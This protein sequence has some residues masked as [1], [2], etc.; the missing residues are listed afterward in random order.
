MAVITPLYEKAELC[1]AS[2]VENEERLLQEFWSK[3]NGI[4]SF[5]WN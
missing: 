2:E 5:N 4:K 1:D 3:I